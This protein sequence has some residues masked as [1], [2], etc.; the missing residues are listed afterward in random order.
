M[1][2]LLVIILPLEHITSLK[3]TFLDP[4]SPSKSS[5]GF[6]GRHVLRSRWPGCPGCPGRF[7]SRASRHGRWISGLRAPCGGLLQH[8]G[9][10][11]LAAS[12]VMA[13]Y[14]QILLKQPEFEDETTSS[15]R[16]KQEIP[17]RNH[18]FVLDFFIIFIVGSMQAG[19]YRKNGIV[20]TGFHFQTPVRRLSPEIC[21]VSHVA[22]GWQSSQLHPVGD[23]WWWFQDLDAGWWNIYRKS[24]KIS[25]I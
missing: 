3:T 22:F 18:A 11:R 9:A 24:P 4:P 19:Y 10:G 6:R 1:I 8:P 12:Q 25:W 21:H 16:H 17:K 2:Y 20:A 14:R 13:F 15:F 5:L 23:N 7:S